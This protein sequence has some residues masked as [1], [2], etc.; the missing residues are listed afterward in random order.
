GHQLFARQIAGHTEDD[1]CARP[2]DPGHPLVSLVAQRVHP[3]VGPDAA[4]VH[5]SPILARALIT[6]SGLLLVQLALGGFEQFT[7]RLLELVHALDLE[8]LED[9]GHVDT[10]G[11]ELVEDG[12]RLVRRTTDGVALDVAVIGDGVHRLL[13]HGVHRVGCYELRDVERVRIVRVLHPGRRPEH[14][15]Y[16]GAAV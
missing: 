12:L 14:A 13:R 1:D 15:L 8:H 3:V 5:R 2:G 6:H 16:P 10:G 4:V 11:L 9:V 7:P